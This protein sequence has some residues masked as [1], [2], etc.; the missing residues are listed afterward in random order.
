MKTT[1]LLLIPHG[2]VT[3][4]T[5]D[6]KGT[7]ESGSNVLSE[8]TSPDTEGEGNLLTIKERLAMLDVAFPMDE[9]VIEGTAPRSPEA[10]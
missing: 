7:Q 8:S 10:G 5:K 9:A 4:L 1:R 2:R 6:S 3:D